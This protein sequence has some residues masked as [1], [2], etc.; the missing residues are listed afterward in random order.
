MKRLWS[1]LLLV[2]FVTLATAQECEN[3]GTPN[4]TSSN[5]CDCPTGFG[6]DLCSQPACGGTIFEGGQRPLTPPLPGETF[7]N[8]TAS[9]CEGLGNGNGGDGE[10]TALPVPGLP[11][12]SGGNQTLACNTSPRVY[13]ASHMSCRVNNPTLRAIYPLESTL[14]ILRTLQPSLTPLPNTTAFGSEG[15]VY[16]Q[17]FYAGEEQFYCS[18]DSCSQRIR[19]SDGDHGPRTDWNCQNLK[20]TCR[21]GTAF[22]GAVRVSN[23]TAAINGLKDTLDIECDALDA[24]TGE[25]TC[26]FRQATLN[27]LFGQGGLVLDGCI[28][29]ECVAQDV[30]DNNGNV[31]NTV[32]DEEEGGGAALSGGVIAGL[33]VVGALV[34]LALVLLLWGLKKQRD[35][36]RGIGSGRFD[37]IGGKKLGVVWNDV[38]YVVPG[39]KAGLWD[40]IMRRGGTGEEGDKTILDNV[41]GVLRSGQMMAILGPS[42][43]GKTTLIELLAGKSKSGI[44]TG[45]ITFPSESQSGTASPRI[46]FVPQQDILPPT[47]TVYEAILFAAGL[48]LPE[49]IP[50]AEKRQRVLE[51]MEKLGISHLVNVRIGYNGDNSGGKRRGISGGEMRRVSIGLELIARPDVLIL[52]EPTS[53]L[54]SVSASRVAKVLQDI[55][56]DPVNPTPVIASIHQPSS[57]LYQTF[58]SIMLLSH[59]RAL[60]CGPGSSAPAEYFSQLGSSTVPPC[61]KGY[62]VADYLLEVASD[63]PVQLFSMSPHSPTA[64]ARE[65]GGRPSGDAVGARGVGGGNSSPDLATEKVRARLSEKGKGGWKQRGVVGQLIPPRSEYATTFLTQLQCLSGREWK[66][67]QRDVTLFFTHMAVS[68]VL[69]VFCGGLYYQTDTSISGFQSRVG[70]LFFLGALIAFSS[71]SALYNVVEIRPLFL[72]ERS[73]SYYSPTAWLMSRFFF[74]VIPLRIIPTLIVSTM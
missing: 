53:G 41:N 64:T 61:P 2:T 1:T 68:C 28:F 67:L 25:S 3:Y 62:N 50:D 73:S 56:H 6:G 20:C 24:T 22:C 12:A 63:P 32:G 33:A 5:Q 37:D 34:G 11:G 58:D 55:A 38:S 45:S 49:T 46:G 8:L 72:R 48:R 4:A 51:I 26:R 17:L 59:G 52:D 15:S 54:D 16:A 42:G 31:T 60:Y 74:D 29:G 70:C 19:D 10:L 43:A 13:A 71:L 30:I 66:I 39:A 27:S 69:G 35:A 21:P 65:D 40:K 47:L 36:R 18:A 23:L 7:S 9:G 44:F 14:N 57:Q